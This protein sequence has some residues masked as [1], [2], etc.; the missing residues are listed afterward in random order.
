MVGA[1]VQ[2]FDNKIDLM[3]VTEFCTKFG[4]SKKTVYDWRYRPEKNKVPTDLVVRLRGKLFIRTDVLKGLISSDTP[5][6]D[7]V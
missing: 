4:Y 2:V 6:L 5:Y 7:G 3:S 1:V